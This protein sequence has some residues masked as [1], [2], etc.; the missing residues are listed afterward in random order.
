MNTSPV[1]LVADDDP[2][3]REVAVANLEANGF[4]TAI[5]TDGEEAVEQTKKLHPAAVLMDIEMP[6]KDGIEA[7]K[8]LQED[9]ATKDVRVILV[10][11]FKDPHIG[12]DYFRKDGDFSFLMRQ[13]QSLVTA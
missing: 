2:G 11:N 1:I 5:A 9:S 8:E 10:S 6:N 7:T 4:K 3:F 12:V 13:V